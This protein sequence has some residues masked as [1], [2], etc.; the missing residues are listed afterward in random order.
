M[1]DRQQLEILLARRFPG[2][3]AEQIAAACNAIMA[4]DEPCTCAPAR[5]R[6]RLLDEPL[7]VGGGAAAPIAGHPRKLGR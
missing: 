4:L 5:S 3:T 6:H 7:S 1:R 2:S